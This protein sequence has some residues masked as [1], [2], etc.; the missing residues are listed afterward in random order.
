MDPVPDPSPDPGKLGREDRHPDR[1]STATRFPGHG[2]ERGVAGR[3]PARQRGPQ[4]AD[5]IV[6]A[7][8]PALLVVRNGWDPGWQAT[9]DGRPTPVLVTD[10]LLQGIVVPAGRHTVELR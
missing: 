9:V 3:G 1:W 6:D 5:V 8:S 2:V 7:N 4:A 10:Y